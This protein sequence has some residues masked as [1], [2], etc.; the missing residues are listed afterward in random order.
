[1]RNGFDRLRPSERDRS[2]RLLDRARTRAPSGEIKLGRT[3]S[4]AHG[5]WRSAFEVQPVNTHSVPRLYRREEN[6]LAVGMKGG[7]VR[8][9]IEDER[10]DGEE[11]SPGRLPSAGERVESLSSP[12]AASA[13]LPSGDSAIAKPSPSRTAGEPSVPRMY[14]G[15]HRSGGIAAIGEEQ[16][17]VVRRQRDGHGLIQ[18]LQVLLGL[19]GSVAITSKLSSFLSRSTRPSRETSCKKRSPP[20]VATIRSCPL[21]STAWTSV[22][23]AT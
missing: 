2:R 6:A 1:M 18:P 16:G 17:P 3:P 21:R 15:G 20:S 4:D 8:E 7:P 19:P 5:P 11:W 13:H 22:L 10:T 23:S 12:R 9:A 14:S